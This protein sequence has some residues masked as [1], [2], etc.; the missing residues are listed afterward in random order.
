MALTFLSCSKM[1]GKS[2]VH[3]KEFRIFG[4]IFIRALH[5]HC[6]CN[7]D[8]DL[9]VKPGVHR[10]KKKNEM[11]TTIQNCLANLHIVSCLHI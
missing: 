7:I 9:I 11:K 5:N 6:N 4:C 2:L 8:I 3:A 1:L 10:H